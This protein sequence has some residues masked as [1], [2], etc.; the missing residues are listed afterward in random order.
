MKVEIVG[1][2]GVVGNATYQWFCKMRPKGVEL[3]R[4]DLGD[5]LPQEGA[6]ISFLCLPEDVIETNCKM[7]QSYADLVVIR[8]TTPPGTCERLNGNTHVCHNPEFLRASSPVDDILNPNYILIGACCAFHAKI[9]RDLFSVTC[10]EVVVTDP[11]TSEIVKIATNNYLACLIS[12]WNE[13]DAIA[14]AY[15]VSG[16]QVGAIASRDVRVTNYGSRWHHKFDGRCLPKD[17]DQMIQA[18]KVKAVRSDLLQAVRAV[19]M[20]IRSELL[21]IEKELIEGVVK[22]QA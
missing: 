1:Y 22:C 20:G 8:S 5:P 18:A 15:G 6:S 16:H 9:L 17:L 12:F 3:I 21:P 11:T 2:K 4:R 7:A 10:S 13:I 19:N 14:T